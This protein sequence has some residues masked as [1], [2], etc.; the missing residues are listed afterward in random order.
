MIDNEHLNLLLH[1]CNKINEF[2]LEINNGN[3]K[4]SGH[5]LLNKAG[6]SVE[7]G[8][9]KKST[10][11]FSTKSSMEP[12]DWNWAVIKLAVVD[13]NKNCAIYVS[14]VLWLEFKNN[15]IKIFPSIYVS[16]DDILNKLSHQ[17]NYTFS[18]INDLSLAKNKKVILQEKVIAENEIYFNLATEIKNKK[19]DFFRIVLKSCESNKLL[20]KQFNDFILHDTNDFDLTLEIKLDMSNQIDKFILKKNLEENLNTK[21]IKK[22]KKI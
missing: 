5:V 3:F 10:F 4:K 13:Q 2:Q 17:I 7:Q 9:D 21:E 14:D 18:L 16:N 6:V 8:V 12:E 20:L 1:Q 19:A 22:N 15:K 11:K